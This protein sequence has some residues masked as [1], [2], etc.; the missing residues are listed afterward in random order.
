MSEV[1]VVSVD[2]IT[3][4]PVDFGYQTTVLHDACATLDLEFEGVKVPAAQVRA[5]LMAALKFGYGTFTV[6][7]DISRYTRATLF[8]HVGN[9]PHSRLFS[10]QYGSVGLKDSQVGVQSQATI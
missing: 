10:G 4:A 5:A 8:S 9:R 3:R 1:L 6:T 7:H 2:G